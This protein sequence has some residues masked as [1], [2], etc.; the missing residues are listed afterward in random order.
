MISEEARTLIDQAFNHHPPSDLDVGHAHGFIRN[1]L[2]HVALVVMQ[3][4][5]GSRE[6]S[7]ALTKLEEAM[8]WANS[9]IARNQAE[10][11]E[12]YRS[13]PRDALQS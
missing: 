5:P 1:E 12:R 8:F 9:A 4:C 3:L 2:K 10:A 7:L 11:L 13:S 6:R